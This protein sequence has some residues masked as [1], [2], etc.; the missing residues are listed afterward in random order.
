MI[1][2]NLDF[3]DLY[4]KAPVLCLIKWVTLRSIHLV[5]TMWICGKQKPDD[6]K[7]EFWLFIIFMAN[8]L[9]LVSGKPYIHKLSLLTSSFVIKTYITVKTTC[10]SELEAEFIIAYLSI[11][12]CAWI[13]L[14][15]IGGH[16]GFGALFEWLNYFFTSEMDSAYLKT[17]LLTP[18]L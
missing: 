5:E 7:S 11:T 3:W 18:R 15:E 8:I 1:S 2:S 4:W 16:L 10:C 13:F 12:N 9:K 14:V 17:I 6:G